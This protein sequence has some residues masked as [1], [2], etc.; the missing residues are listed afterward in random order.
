MPLNPSVMSAAAGEDSMSSI[1]LDNEPPMTAAEAGYNLHVG[2]EQL[3]SLRQ[4]HVMLTGK[5]P[6]SLHLNHCSSMAYGIEDNKGVLG[7]FAGG[8]L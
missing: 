8:Q 7:C 3:P 4:N 5:V 2:S 1:D 6:K